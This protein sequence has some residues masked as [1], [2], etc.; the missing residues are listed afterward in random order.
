MPVT[1]SCQTW[2]IPAKDVRSLVWV[3][4]SL[5]DWAAGGIRYELDGSIDR[6]LVNYAFPFDAACSSPSGKYAVLY[7]RLGTKGLVL[8][9]GAILREINRS[10]YFASV[11]E[12]PVVIAQLPSEQEVLIHCPEKYNRIDFDDLVAG[13]RLTRSTERKPCD[14]FHSRFATDGVFLLSAGWIWHPV[15]GVVV[16]RLDE[17]LADACTLDDAGLLPMPGTEV[18][19]AALLANG[20]VALATSDETFSDEEDLA[21][22]NTVRPNSLAVWDLNLGTLVS[23]VPVRESVGTMLSLRDGFVASFYDH[24]KVFDLATGQVVWRLA[25]LKT[26]TQTSSIIHHLDQQPVLALDPAHSRFAVAKENEI[27]VV[28]LHCER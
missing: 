25:D 27:R 1:V 17:A 19:T 3:G 4:D 9:N 15:D 21:L 14:F 24:P 20:R 23:Q 26:G 8:R 13:T 7:T 6:R 28:R 5:A 2:T 22:P 16:H 12:Y 11:Y 10:Y 18:N